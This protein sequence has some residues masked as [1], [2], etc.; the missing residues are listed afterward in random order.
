MV[1]PETDTG[2]KCVVCDEPS[3]W[4]LRFP[5][6]ALTVRCKKCGTSKVVDLNDS[7][8]LMLMCANQVW[9]IGEV[10]KDG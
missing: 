7:M 2:I 1:T 4:S 10:I 8:S 9:K 3:D 6:K 5:S